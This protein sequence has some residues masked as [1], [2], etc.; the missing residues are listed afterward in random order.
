[1]PPPPNFFNLLPRQ[2]SF[3]PVPSSYGSASSSPHPG[4]VA[5]IVIGSVGGFLLLLFLIYSCLGFGPSVWVQP[6]RSEYTAASQSVLSFRTRRTS[7]ARSA[8]RHASRGP[9]VTET[10]E[11]RTRE[12]RERPVVVE[13]PP[14]VVEATRAPPPPRVVRS[15][16]SEDDEDEIVVLEEHSPPRRKSRRRSSDR[17]RSE[18][19]YSRGG[20]SYYHDAEPGSPYR[21][22]RDRRYSRE[23]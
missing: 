23:R 7:R 16:D 10:Y 14:V 11:V 17:R 2:S 15:E 6:S 1:M 13:E 18:E 4:V 21:E 3:V 19:R 12:R 5:G 9:R 20:G 8:R 22:R